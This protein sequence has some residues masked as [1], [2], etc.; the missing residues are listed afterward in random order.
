MRRLNINLNR[1][2][3]AVRAARGS[4]A[5]PQGSILELQDAWGVI[6]ATLVTLDMVVPLARSPREPQRRA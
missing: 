5:P 2:T 1:V 3:E 4:R 6:R